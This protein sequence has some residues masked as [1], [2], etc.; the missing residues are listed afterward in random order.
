MASLK[1]VST[2]P[3]PDEYLH[4]ALHATSPQERARLAQAGLDAAARDG[5]DPD[6][7]VLLLRQLYLAHLEVGRFR[8][9]ATVALAMARVGP[10]RDVAH[11]DAS[12]ALAAI[13]DLE[14]AVAQQRLAARASPPERRSFH[15]WSLGTLLQF[16]GDFSGAAAAIA[17]GERWAHADRPLLRAHRAWVRLEA[18]LPVRGLAG[19]VAELERAKCREGYGQL[20][21]GML[22]HLMGDRRRAAVHLRAFLRRNASA[23]VGKKV[24]LREELRRARVALAE[25]ES[26]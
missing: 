17:R 22:H 16:S 20:V 9:A 13:G 26:D 11:H 12:R 23:D 18:G 2:S 3:G 6:T 21:L 14:G 1:E 15:Y 24:T 10:L 7:E 4:R 25:I 19:I 5:L 8:D